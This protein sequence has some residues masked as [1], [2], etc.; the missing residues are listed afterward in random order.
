MADGVSSRPHR[1]GPIPRRRSHGGIGHGVLTDSAGGATD[2]TARAL[3]SS[4]T[5]PG[6][7]RRALMKLLLMPKQQ[8]PASKT[9]RALR[10]RKR[11]LLGVG[12]F[13]ALQ[14]LQSREGSRTCPAHMRSRFVG[15]GWREGRGASLN[16]GRLRIRS[17]GW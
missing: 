5:R 9:S 16:G 8:V 3:P 7:G 2:R 13:M 11:F 1:R 12:A 6:G 4:T 14:V 15:L 17:G 10:T